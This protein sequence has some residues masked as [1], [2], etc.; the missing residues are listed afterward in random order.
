VPYLL[1]TFLGNPG[2]DH[3]LLFMAW[4]L[5]YMS[6]YAFKEWIKKRR[7]EKRL[8]IWAINYGLA[9]LIFLIIPLEKE[10]TLA[11]VSPFLLIS[12]IVLIWHIR[13]RKERAMAN[14]LGALHAFSMGGV[15][16]YV[17][18]TW[19]SSFMYIMSFSFWE[20]SFS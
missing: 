12:V 4:L 8:A 16:A 7:R 2:W 9:G 5:F 15:A 18:G 14:D 3:V 1:G 13:K 10:P 19:L 11:F 6:T 20:L 17:L